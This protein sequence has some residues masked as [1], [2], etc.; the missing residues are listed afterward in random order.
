MKTLGDP[1]HLR[2]IQRMGV[3]AMAVGTWLGQRCFRSIND[4]IA[5]AGL[6]IRREGEHGL[7]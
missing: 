4:G 3:T 2:A 5:K 1:V 7:N 6:I